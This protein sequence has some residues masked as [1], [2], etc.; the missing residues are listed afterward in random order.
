[1]SQNSVSVVVLRLP[2]GSSEEIMGGTGFG[3]L[4]K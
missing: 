3:Q 2:F 4:A 1:M